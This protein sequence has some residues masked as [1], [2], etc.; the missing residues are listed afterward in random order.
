MRKS[1][2]ISAAA[3]AAFCL[4][5]PLSA[6]TANPQTGQTPPS[7][8]AQPQTPT[9]APP[10]TQPPAAVTPT[11]TPAAPVGTTGT[12]SPATPSTGATSTGTTSIADT[13]HGTAILLLERVQKVLDD[14]AAGKTGDVTIE[15][16]LLDELRAE[17][18]QV[19]ASLKPAK[20]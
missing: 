12:M 9:G 16:G 7:T 11:P 20:P 18:S 15:R 13:E 1:H 8:Q 2:S 5:A 19:R 17:V 14:A 10:P 3:L 6:Q 4:T